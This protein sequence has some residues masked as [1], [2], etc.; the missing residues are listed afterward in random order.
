MSNTNF[1]TNMGYSRTVSSG[2]SSGGSKGA[3]PTG[4][5]FDTNIEDYERTNTETTS[6]SVI[7]E[8]GSLDLGMFIE[9]G[10]VG[11]VGTAKI[12]DSLGITPAELD[13]RAWYEKALDLVSEVGATVAVGATSIVS[14][15]LDLGEGLL[16]GVVWAGAT[17][18]SWFGVD[19]TGAKEFMA[20]DLVGEANQ[21]FY[22]NTSIGQAINDASYMKY[23]SD[24]AQGIRNTT[25]VAAEIAA[26]TALTVATGGAAA[27]FV[28]GATA[29]L[30]YAAE[31]TYQTHGTDTTFMQELGIAGSGALTGLSWMAN[32]KLGAG[33]LNIAKDCGALGAKNV[34]SGLL[35]E[36]TT[37]DF[38][39][40]VL[41]EGLSL[42]NSNNKLNIN[43]LLNYLTSA[44]GTAG[45]LTPYITGEEN[46][47]GTAGLK[48]VGTYISYLGLNILEDVFRDQI[49][50]YTSQIPD[51]VEFSQPFIDFSNPRTE[52]DKKIH[53]HTRG[54]D[55]S[56]TARQISIAYL[57]EI[58]QDESYVSKLLSGD[59]TDEID[60]ITKLEIGNAL[61]DLQI[62][63]NKNGY[64][65][66]FNE[67]ELARLQEFIDKLAK[68]PLQVNFEKFDEIFWK[69]YNKNGNANF[70]P[71]FFDSEDGQAALTYVRNIGKENFWQLPT[72]SLGI[73]LGVY[74][75]VLAN[76]PQ[77][78]Y[79]IKSQAMFNDFVTSL[80]SKENITD[81]DARYLSNLLQSS[82][83]TIPHH[84]SNAF[85]ELQR[86]M[87]LVDYDAEVAK[88]LGD[89]AGVYVTPEKVQSIIGSCE[90]QTAA[91]FAQH[92]TS[93]TA[94]AYNN[95]QR[96]V[97][98]LM[99]ELRIIKDNVNHESL[100]QISAD[101]ITN[102][103]SMTG[104]RISL[105][106]IQ[107]SVWSPTSNSWVKQRTGLNESITEY[108]SK[109][110]MGSEFTNSSGYAKGVVMLESL[111][112]NGFISIDDLKRFY[113]TND[114]NGLTRY[115]DNLS[116]QYGLSYSSEDIFKA[117]DK[118]ISR[119]YDEIVDGEKELN[120]I[121]K[122]FMI[123]Y[124]KT[125]SPDTTTTP[126]G[127]ISFIK[128]IF[129]A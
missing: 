39:T 18:A 122:D 123:K 93:Q 12:T 78:G 86:R 102:F 66:G 20:R 28:V 103:D 31:S 91:V 105:A 116:T 108:F 30:G 54:L 72:N 48:L 5:N 27:P 80:V 55:L 101:T 11:T 7:E 10:E 99:Y 96:S 70:S 106:G 17:V 69:T 79:I 92:T 85:E 119:N 42:K 1:S 109:L 63:M 71:E 47:D 52:L 113:F 6:S 53:I 90:Y 43:A 97:M 60:G 61:L 34:I 32:G 2:N 115:I 62:A 35:K 127:L 24:T 51:P 41:K 50:T 4:W 59:I 83:F 77:N 95:G 38:W 81:L 120:K 26:A 56:A 124:G 129:G 21:A 40:N 65:L 76:L 100:H 57:I 112:D 14:G 33:A 111:V 23:D 13:N 89:F 114:G 49:S 84:L 45:S 107:R 44:F 73:Y 82:N 67:V 15:V 8:D 110:T 29:G 3:T 75:D 16:D 25:K 128:G 87:S 22:E 46:F 117:F 125:V 64:D 94:M 36:M 19:T 104:E 121:L 126:S 68:N 88:R 58:V 118:I 9:G 74:D 98:N 37:K